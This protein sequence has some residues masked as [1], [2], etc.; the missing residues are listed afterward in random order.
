MH[1]R[2]VIA[3]V[4]LVVAAL[5][6][7]VG[8]RVDT[9]V[10]VDVAEDGSGAVEVGVTLDRD[11]VRRLGGRLR[12]VVEVDDLRSAG[13]E[14][15]GPRRIDGGGAEVAV[16][17]AFGTPDEGARVMRE[18]TG[19]R[20]PL[21]GFRFERSTPFARTD[22]AVEGVLDLRDG[23]EAFGDEG[24]AAE[25]DGLPIGRPVDELEAE[26]GEPLSDVVGVE[27]RLRLPG[28]DAESNADVRAA[29]GGT[30]E[31][32][33]GDGPVRIHATTTERRTDVLAW[34]GGA[35]VV[36]I[37]LV[38]LLL[39]RVALAWRRRRR[40]RLGTHVAA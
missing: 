24:L 22:W 36:A 16:T 6:A 39:V 3:L 28:G 26:L 25:L 1:R 23:I 35:V 18:V 8:C 27:V 13:W 37:V 31:A 2:R 11:A 15:D 14:I 21:R 7:G 17:K 9:T 19:R 33:L 32:R 30:W 34:L 4:G 5:L 20:G 10:T 40:A 29:D 12:Q 38:V